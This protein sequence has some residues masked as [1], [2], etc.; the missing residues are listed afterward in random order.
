MKVLP[1]VAFSI[2]LASCKYSRIP[3]PAPPPPTKEQKAV[4]A[5]FIDERVREIDKRLSISFNKKDTNIKRLL[6]VQKERIL[7]K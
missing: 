3:A 4:I 7:A 1:L 6:L 5:G 2:F